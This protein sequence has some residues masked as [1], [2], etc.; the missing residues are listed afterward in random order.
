MTAAHS[1][2]FIINQSTYVE[3]H[4][5]LFYFTV[6]LFEFIGKDDFTVRFFS[7]FCGLVTCIAGYAAA[8]LVLP[9]PQA[10]TALVLLMVNTQFLFLIRT[11]RPY[12]CM[13]ALFALIFFLY[14]RLSREDQFRPGLTALLG[15]LLGLSFSLVYT[16]LFIIVAVVGCLG[17]LGLLARRAVPVWRAVLLGLAVSLFVASFYALFIAKSS[18]SQAY[19][20]ASM[21]YAGITSIYCNAL[22]DNVFYFNNLPLRLSLAALALHGLW[23]LRGN[24]PFFFLTLALLAVP[25]VQL[26]VTHTALNF[27]GR[28]IA[29][30]MFPLAMAQAC[31]ATALLSRFGRPAPALAAVALGLAVLIGYHHKFY[32]VDS[33]DVDII[34]DNYKLVAQRLA[35][36]ATPG[37]VLNFTGDYLEKCTGWYLDRYIAPTARL[38]APGAD[39][40]VSSVIVGKEYTYVG[41]NKE[42]FIKR[43]GPFDAEEQFR[44][45]TIFR[46][47]V[48]KAGPTD[49]AATPFF[50]AFAFDYTR[51]YA[52]AAALADC[53]LASSARGFSMIATRPDTPAV[54]DYA[55]TNSGGNTHFGVVLDYRSAGWGNVVAVDVRFD[56]A[57]F[58]QVFATGGM[59]SRRQAIIHFEHDAPFTTMTVRLRLVCH[60]S[61]PSSPGS[62]LRTVGL[63]GFTVIAAKD[64]STVNNILGPAAYNAYL[65]ENYESE[66]FPAASGI[67]QHLAYD[68]NVIQCARPDD[69]EDPRAAMCSLRPGQ[70]AGDIDIRYTAPHNDAVFLP[71]ISGEDSLLTAQFIMPDGLPVGFFTM[72]G[73][74][75]SRWTPAAAQYKL[76]L[77]KLDGAI[78]V[79]LEGKAQL[80]TVDGKALFRAR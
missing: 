44:S 7:V 71:R 37:Q 17:L 79:H 57:P 14:L 46:R 51:F 34:G 10:R 36:T 47:A 28:H 53:S 29:F 59:D 69:V 39:A 19:L 31:S 18:V 6:K 35:D 38:N 68:A 66:R 4:P 21:D 54:C 26:V 8:R 24:Q 2:E 45:V 80:W 74:S 63:E 50:R 30:L 25:Y 65:L 12:A 32:A 43:F 48:A 56:D 42:G 55:F 1:L 22:L 23:L 77:P 61:L 70:A 64:A 41:G 16:S 60:D 13:V 72:R 58:V 33:Y 62:G 67:E 9:L 75:N 76:P 78:R 27:W 3:V 20:N 49:M 73:N 52:E 5:P 40:P 11:V 15:L